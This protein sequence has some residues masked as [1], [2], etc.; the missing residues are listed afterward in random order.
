MKVVK[1][2]GGG[3]PTCAHLLCVPGSTATTSSSSPTAPDELRLLAAHDVGQSVRARDE[4]ARARRTSSPP[5]VRASRRGEI[6]ER[7][8]TVDVRRL[9]PA[10]AAA[11]H[12]G[13]DARQ[14]E[15]APV[16]EQRVEGRGEG[17]VAHGQDAERRV[18]VASTRPCSSASAARAAVVPQSTAMSAASPMAFPVPEPEDST[19]R[20]PDWS[21]GQATSRT[22]ARAGALRFSAP[23]AAPPRRRWRAPRPSAR[24]ARCAPSSRTARAS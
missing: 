14:R 20:R 6:V 22:A 21:S 23:S 18:R 13:G 9:D 24:P 12:A 8:G 19:A 2:A 10:L 15:R 1:S 11:D 3:P 4:H 16:A 7:R 17:A 5:G